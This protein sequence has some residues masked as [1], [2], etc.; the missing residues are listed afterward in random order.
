MGAIEARPSL[1]VELPARPD[2]AREAR[3]LVLDALSDVAVDRDAVALVVTEAVSNA[4]VHGCPPGSDATRVRL[5]ATVDADTVEIEV[6]DDGPGLR[7][8]PDSPGAGLGLAI[9]GSLADELE[10]ADGQGTRLRIRFAVLGPAGPHSLRIPRRARRVQLAR[11]AH[12][13]SG[14]DASGWADSP[15]NDRPTAPLGVA[16]A[17]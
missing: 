10:L 8:R 14:D 11:A 17:A 13:A 16:A 1:S 12:G 4:I 3:R 5:C 2:S 6:A 15:P 7:P 9:M